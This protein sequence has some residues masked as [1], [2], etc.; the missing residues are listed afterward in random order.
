MKFKKVARDSKNKLLTVGDILMYNDGDGSSL[1]V[2]RRIVRHGRDRFPSV[3]VLQIQTDYIGRVKGTTK[4]TLTVDTYKTSH[5]M[6]PSTLRDDVQ[7]YRYAK[8]LRE[9]VTAKGQNSD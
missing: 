7:S 8:E 5:V 9:T 2:V 1:G 6:E 4:H 3:E